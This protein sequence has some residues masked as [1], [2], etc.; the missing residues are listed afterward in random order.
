M[1]S[2]AFVSCGISPDDIRITEVS[3]PRESNVGLSQIR[4]VLD[5]TVANDSRRNITVTKGLI[6]VIDPAGNEIADIILDE[7]FTLDKRSETVVPLHLTVR[8]KNPLGVVGMAMMNGPE[9]L[10]SARINYLISGRSGSVRKAFSGKN[11]PLAVLL[12]DLGMDDF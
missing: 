10:R 7:G 4:M 5:M 8:P 3:A 2:L 6:T 9:A 12:R 11:V 1:A